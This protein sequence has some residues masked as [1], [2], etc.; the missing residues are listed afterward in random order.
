MDI[1]EARNGGLILIYEQGISSIYLY[2]SCCIC[3]LLIV[4]ITVNYIHTKTAKL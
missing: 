4:G 1:Q 3:V 2:Y